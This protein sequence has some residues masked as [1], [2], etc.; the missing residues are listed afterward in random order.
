MA[1]EPSCPQCVLVSRQLGRRV[2]CLLHA[3]PPVLV[4]GLPSQAQANGHLGDHDE[5]YVVGRAEPSVDAPAPFSLREYARLLVLRSKVR[6]QRGPG[7][8]PL[9]APGIGDRSDASPAS[10]T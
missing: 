7:R 8:H 6:E 10:R 9:P 2:S 5:P 4:D 1:F 3:E